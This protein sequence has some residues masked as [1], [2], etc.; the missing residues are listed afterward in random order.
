[1]LSERLGV[2]EEAL[3]EEL[4]TTIGRP[5]VVGKAQRKRD[6]GAAMPTWEEE[7]IHILVNYPQWIP[8]LEESKVLEHF[9]GEMWKEVGQ[10]LL[11]H[12]R[13]TGNLDLGGL[14]EEIEDEQVGA[15]VSRWSLEQRPWSEEDARLRLQERFEGIGAG[16][17]RLQEDLRR[18]QEEILA[19][20]RS[21][22][23]PLLAELLAEKQAKKLALLAE[24]ADD[25]ID[26]SKGE[27]V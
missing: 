3:W 15:M 5:K 4:G 18:L 6:R 21:K 9:H 17:R 27:M 20:E 12:C 25:K 24:T 11:K 19:A 7:V 16:R 22:N 13:G 14:L 8:V 26:L 1:M 23:E 10:L 2:S